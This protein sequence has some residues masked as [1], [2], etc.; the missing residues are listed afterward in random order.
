MKV[1]PLLVSER[2]PGLYRKLSPSPA[3]PE[4]VKNPPSLPTD[5][6]LIE[7]SD[8]RPR[9]SANWLLRYNR[10]E[11]RQRACKGE[12]LPAPV[13]IDVAARYTA[14]GGAGAVHWHG[15]LVLPAPKA[16]IGEH[17]RPA[18]SLTQ[19]LEA[20]SRGAPI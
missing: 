14:K 2:R 11:R 18:R 3:N 15:P 20:E 4:N 6:D 13:S 8:M 9:S 17:A 7:F 10:L 5:E 16:Q 12:H 1:S 19:V